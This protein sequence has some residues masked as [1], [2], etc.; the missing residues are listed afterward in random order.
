MK[1]GEAIEAESGYIIGCECHKCKWKGKVAECD[2]ILLETLV[3][4]C[5][6][7]C[8]EI[9]DFIYILETKQC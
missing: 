1:I 8:E 2:N 7:C 3:H 9:D 6:K 4:I 5:P